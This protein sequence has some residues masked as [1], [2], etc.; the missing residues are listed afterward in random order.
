MYEHYLNSFTMEPQEGNPA[1]VIRLTQAP[2]TGSL[3]VVG[4]NFR[5]Q[6]KKA[7]FDYDLIEPQPPTLTAEDPGLVGLVQGIVLA[8]LERRMHED[9]GQQ[10]GSS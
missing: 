2:Y 9:L 6:D 7:I 3:L 8:I 4:K 5:I 10:K 1:F